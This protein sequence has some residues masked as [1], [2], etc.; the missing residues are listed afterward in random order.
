MSIIPAQMNP[1]LTPDLEREVAF[2][3]KW[4]YLVVENA[5]TPA[6]LEDLRSAL[7]ETFDRLKTQFTG[8]LLEQDERFGF[9]IDNPPA[10]TRIKA[11][12]GNCVQLHSATS[13]VTQPGE[14]NQNWHRDGP[15]PMDPNGTPYGSL[16]GQIN[17]G[18]YLDEITMENGPIVIVPGSQRA[19]FKP[20]EGH[21]RFPDEKYILAQPGQAVLFDGW[22]YHR[23]AANTSQQRRHVCLMC[24]QNAWMKSREPFDGPRV[25]KLR[26]EGSPERKLLLGGIPK[27]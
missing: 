16:P 15:W 2:F 17:C 3:L 10:L 18:Y 9:L 21:P 8:E 11:I 20:P 4:G 25:T 22:I 26:E 6:Q 23:G 27:W 12:L 19:L 7:D 5:L 1:D 24:Y 13:R 14:P